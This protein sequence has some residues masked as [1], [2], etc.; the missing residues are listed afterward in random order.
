MVG[1][2]KLILS[3]VVAVFTLQSCWC[4]EVGAKKCLNKKIKTIQTQLA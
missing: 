4:M 1:L 3:L 2:K